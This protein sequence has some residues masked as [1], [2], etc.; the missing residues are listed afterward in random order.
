MDM[1]TTNIN[2]CI[3]RFISQSFMLV[4]GYNQ[5]LSSLFSFPSQGPAET[6]QTILRDAKLFSYDE[7]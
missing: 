1:P 3:T 5:H 2:T 4:I 6:S 7:F